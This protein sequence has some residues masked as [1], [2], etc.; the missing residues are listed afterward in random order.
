MS[1]APKTHLQ[2]F[3]E[4]GRTLYIQDA[5][6]HHYFEYDDINKTVTIETIMLCNNET[7]KIGVYDQNEF[8]SVKS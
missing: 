5:F 1:A 8:G 6:A 2:R 3:D 7:V 4:R